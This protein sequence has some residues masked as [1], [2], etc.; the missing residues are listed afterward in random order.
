MKTI[1]DIDKD[2]IEKAM[3]VSGTGTK[4]ET[5]KIALEELVK[6]KLRQRLKQMAGSGILDI[7]LEELKAIRTRRTKKHLHL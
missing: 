4:K 6:L 7:S 3:K 5:V 2:L 1:I